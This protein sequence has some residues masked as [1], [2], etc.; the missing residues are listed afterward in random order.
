MVGVLRGSD[1]ALADEYVVLSAHL[2]HVGVGAPVNGDSIYNGAMDNASGIAT[3]IEAAAA[4]V[5]GAGRSARCCSS[6]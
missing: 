1:P 2:D 5:G 6:R 4:M 3:L